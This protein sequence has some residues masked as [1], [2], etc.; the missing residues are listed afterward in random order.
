MRP[1]FVVNRDAVLGDFAC[2]PEVFKLI[3]IVYF[4][5]VGFIKE[6]NKGIL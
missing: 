3:G 4:V 6:L 5:V 1:F 2:L